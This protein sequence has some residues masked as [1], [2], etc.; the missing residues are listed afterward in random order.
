M[1]S[2][3]F[4]FTSFLTSFIKLYASSKND[5]SSLNPSSFIKRS[6]CVKD[7]AISASHCSN[8]WMTL[9]YAA[10]FCWSAARCVRRCCL[11]RSSSHNAPLSISASAGEI[12]V[13]GC[14]VSRLFREDDFPDTSQYTIS[15]APKLMAGIHCWSREKRTMNNIPAAMTVFF[16]LACCL[17]K[18]VSC[19][20]SFACSWCCPCV[21]SYALR[22]ASLSFLWLF[23]RI[24]DEAA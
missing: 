9:S 14:L 1:V 8:C 10:S 17:S 2:S 6:T 3:C 18:N 11:L 4:F 7:G 19:S 22:A 20:L 16:C 15:A 13:M 23:S 5:G 12:S 24:A 21:S